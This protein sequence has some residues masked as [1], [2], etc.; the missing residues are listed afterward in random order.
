MKSP[1]K[2]TAAKRKSA[3]VE[4]IKPVVP[5]VRK[6]APDYGSADF[7][8][9]LQAHFYRAKRAALGYE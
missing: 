4:T 5:V 8:L 6:K 2:K 9:A 1:A 7:A 3:P